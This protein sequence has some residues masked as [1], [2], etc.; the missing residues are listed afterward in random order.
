MAHAI[1]LFPLVLALGFQEPRTSAADRDPAALREG[2]V[3]LHLDDAASYTIDRVAD[4]KERAELVREPVYVWTNPVRASRQDGAVFVW[5]CRGRPEAIGSIFSAPTPKL[6]SIN[7]EFHSLSLARLVVTREGS[8]AK[9]WNPAAPGLSMAPIESA[10][11]IAD[12]AP[13]RLAQLRA[14]S[15][16]YTASSLDAKGGRWELRLLPKPLYRYESTDPELVDGAL[17]AFVTSAGTDPEVLLAIEARRPIGGGEPTWQAGFARFSDLELTVHRD[18][19]VVFSAPLIRGNLAE[20]YPKQ[21]YQ[22]FR[23]RAVPKLEGEAP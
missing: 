21:E 13:K 2:L 5:T 3:K 1:L 6:R 8:H 7:H 19:K 20:M 14:I 4:R 18:K 11:A 9:S 10:P 15:R 16:E 22:I 12:S 17:F 23:D